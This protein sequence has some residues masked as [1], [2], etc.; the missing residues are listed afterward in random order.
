MNVSIIKNFLGMKIFK[1]VQQVDDEEMEEGLME[2]PVEEEFEEFTEEELEEEFPEEE[3]ESWE[4]EFEEL[5]E[6]E[7]A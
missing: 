3:E 2:E 7:E 1:L 4:E 5:E 6:E